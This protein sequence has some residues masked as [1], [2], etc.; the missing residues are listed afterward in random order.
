MP[1][2]SYSHLITIDAL[3]L[4]DASWFELQ[5]PRVPVVHARPVSEEKQLETEG[6]SS[7][8]QLM[9]GRQDLIELANGVRGCAGKIE[10]R[11][12][13]EYITIIVCI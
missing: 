5:S 8:Y 2:V 9:P 1:L 7:L 3:S 12:D 4:V 13:K 11:N 10:L 6:K